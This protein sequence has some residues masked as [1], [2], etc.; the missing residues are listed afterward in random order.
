M[1]IGENALV[2]ARVS[3][4]RA[5]T[6]ASAIVDQ[7]RTAA[8]PSLVRLDLAAAAGALRGAGADIAVVRVDAR[9]EPWT[10]TG[11]DASQGAPITWLAHGD[12][13]IA[14]RRGPHLDAGLQLRLRVGM[15]APAIDG[16]GAT[17]TAAATHDG[18]IEVC[19]LFPGE[20]RD[21][22]ERVAYDRTMPRAL[23]GGGF[24]VAV[25]V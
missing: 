5:G 1:G 23:F 4:R 10:R 17:F 2:D 25:A 24:D 9:S 13:W 14:T 16:T 8:P 6:L 19:S 12:S 22:D 11:L 3:W 7:L 15:A 21:D 18:P 20:L